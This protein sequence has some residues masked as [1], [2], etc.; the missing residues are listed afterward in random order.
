MSTNAVLLK[1][2]VPSK[3]IIDSIYEQTSEQ[4]L[5]IFV[6]QV[7]AERLEFEGFPNAY[8]PMYNSWLDHLTTSLFDMNTLVDD[9]IRARVNPKF[10]WSIGGYEF[11][12]AKTFTINTYSAVD[13]YDVLSK[14]KCIDSYEALS[15]ERHNLQLIL[16][17]FFKY[18]EVIPLIKN[19][20]GFFEEEMEKTFV[21]GEMYLSLL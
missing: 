3:E 19:N 10:Y 16:C 15:K 20:S 17:D 11:I 14:E 18:Q 12:L 2:T 6:S 4:N 8:F 21:E 9:F 5:N 13:I 1:L 7:H